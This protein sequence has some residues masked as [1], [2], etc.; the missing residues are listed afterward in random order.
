MS[1][2]YKA[3]DRVILNLLKTSGEVTG[4]VKRKRSVFGDVL[5][6]R[7]DNGRQGTGPDGSWITNAY[8]VRREHAEG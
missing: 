8:C 2:R 3:G 1:E 5:F 6:V 4:T 7:L